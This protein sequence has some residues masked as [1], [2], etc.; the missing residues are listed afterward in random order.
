MKRYFV[1]VTEYYYPVAVEEYQ[2]R[3]R[4]VL[5]SFMAND[6][7]EAV[8]IKINGRRRVIFV[9]GWLKRRREL[10][11]SQAQHQKRAKILDERNQRGI[12]DPDDWINFEYHT[13]IFERQK[14]LKRVLTSEEKKA[15]YKESSNDV[16]DFVDKNLFSLK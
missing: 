12:P 9:F 3:G 6:F 4:E 5:H 2:L 15:I 7:L 10:K 16:F 14:K 13:R 11:K 8:T 1:V